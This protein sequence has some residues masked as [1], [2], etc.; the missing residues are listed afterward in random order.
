M[1]DK[2]GQFMMIGVLQGGGS[3][4][5]SDQVLDPTT[6]WTK[7]SIHTQWIKDIMAGPGNYSLFYYSL[8][9]KGRAGPFQTIFRIFYG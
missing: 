5:G 6:D 3:R 1:R 8:F 2:T 9:Y 7:V 4:C